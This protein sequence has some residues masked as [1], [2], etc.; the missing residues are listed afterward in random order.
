[1]LANLT[2]SQLDLMD[3]IAKLGDYPDPGIDGVRLP[4]GREHGKEPFESM[5]STGSRFG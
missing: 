4:V 5:S 1:M 2:S 3:R